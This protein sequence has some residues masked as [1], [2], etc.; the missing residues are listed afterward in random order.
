MAKDSTVP[1]INGVKRLTCFCFM[2]AMKTTPT[3]AIEVLLNHTYIYTCKE[4]PG[5]LHTGSDTES[6]TH[7]TNTW[8]NTSEGIPPDKLVPK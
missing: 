7:Y 4:K 3:S 8:E 5:L 2:G 6:N 1:L